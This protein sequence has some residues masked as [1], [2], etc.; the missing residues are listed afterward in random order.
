MIIYFHMF[1][2]FLVT[3]SMIWWCRSWGTERFD[4]QKLKWNIEWYGYPWKL[5][6]YPI[7]LRE[8]HGNMFQVI[9]H[10]PV[11]AVGQTDRCGLLAGV[12]LHSGDLELHHQ[13]Q[14]VSYS[15]I[16]NHYCNRVDSS[17]QVFLLSYI[18]CIWFLGCEI[19][20]LIFLGAF[21]DERFRCSPFRSG[22]HI[23]YVLY[24]ITVQKIHCMS[25]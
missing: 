13:I 9:R 22:W 10:W 18:T 16:H 6:R 8:H 7:L 11:S 4:R 25:I 5:E 12:G 24:G 20:S 23:M 3:N 2:S 15:C 1:L 14:L 17:I 19:Y 21:F